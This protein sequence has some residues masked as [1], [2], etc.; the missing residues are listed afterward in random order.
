MRISYLPDIKDSV[1]PLIN[2]SFEVLDIWVAEIVLGFDPHHVG[3]RYLTRLDHSSDIFRT[4]TFLDIHDISFFD[5]STV[6]GEPYFDGKT[7]II[8]FH[9]R[10]DL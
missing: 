10:I 7:D 9:F 2:I 6:G 4:T 1:D 5:G 8:V 3:I